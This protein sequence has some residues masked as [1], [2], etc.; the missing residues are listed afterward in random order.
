VDKHVVESAIV[1]FYES[2]E[3]QDREHFVA[4]AIFP[5]SFD[6]EVRVREPIAS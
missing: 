5:G 3:E 4:L 6:A 1:S 2:L